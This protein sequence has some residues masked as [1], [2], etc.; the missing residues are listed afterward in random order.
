MRKKNPNSKPIF[1][2]EIGELDKPVNELIEQL[3]ID[4]AKI[5]GKISDIRY[6]YGWEDRLDYLE[7]GI[8]CMIVAMNS[9]RE[10]IKEYELKTNT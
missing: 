5:R 4:L 8:T 9:S 6:M 3:R 2:K 1:Y 10:E 7:G